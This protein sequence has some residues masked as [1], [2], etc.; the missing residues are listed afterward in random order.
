MSDLLAGKSCNLAGVWLA[1][2]TGPNSNGYRPPLGIKLLNVFLGDFLTMEVL[3]LST[4]LFEYRP[5]C[6]HNADPTPV[7]HGRC[8]VNYHTEHSFDTR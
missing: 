1:H 5:S 2:H 7:V 8:S 4:D 3:T 6:I